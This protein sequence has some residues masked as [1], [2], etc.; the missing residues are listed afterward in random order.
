MI[1]Q[2]TPLRFL[3]ILAPERDPALPVAWNPDGSLV[4][5][6]AFRDAA[7]ALADKL[8]DRPETRYA[9]C[10]EDA[11]LL[12]AALLGV[13]AAGKQVV[14][15]G[16]TRAQVLR[17]QRELFDRVVTDIAEVAEM[18]EAT[19]STPEAAGAAGAAGTAGITFNTSGSTGTPKSVFKSIEHM[20]IENNIQAARWGGRLAG[21]IVAGTTSHQHLYGLQFRVLLPLTIGVPFNARLLEYH[22]ELAAFADSQKVALITSPAFL[23]R[24]DPALPRPTVTHVLSAGGFLA[25]ADA[26]RC[27]DALG[28]WPFEI[29]GSTE[30]GAIAWRD[31]ALERRLW[32]PLPCVQPDADADGR[33]SLRSDFLPAGTVLVTDDQIRFEPD[34]SGRFELLGRLDRSLKIEEKRIS[35]P[36]IE[37]RLLALDGVADAALAPLRQGERTVLGAVLVLDA[38]GSAHYAAL[39]HGRYLLWLREQ[40]RGT[41]EPVALPRRLRV[42]NQIPYNTQG[43]RTTGDIVA[44]LTAS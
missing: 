5:L 34:N 38:A 21:A 7:L 11:A 37:R 15:P 32:T 13:L 41:V 19:D 40:L 25:P 20:E 42:V 8:R 26:Q 30:A 17:E 36:E 43:K 14:L 31:N 18:A 29:F 44:L 9:L 27:F 33:L 22:E 39:G 1:P 24:L 10:F 16:H 12:A 3:E 35:L 23:K 28:I 2:P 4:R 6:G